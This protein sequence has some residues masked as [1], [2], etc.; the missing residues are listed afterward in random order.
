MDSILIAGGCGFIGS[1]FV[2][3]YLNAH[4]KARVAVLDK[5]TYAG[6]PENLA[7]LKGNPR[8]TFVRGDIG[9][10]A[11]VH[12]WAARVD[13]IVNFAAE[14]HVDRSLTEPDAFLRTGVHGVYT[15]LEAVRAH[16][17]VKRFLQI[18]TDE[19]YGSIE[20]GSFAE[21]DLLAPSSP[22]SAA[23][24]AGDL[25]VLAYRKTWELPILLTRASNNYGPYQ[26]PEKLIPL[27]VTNAL[28]DQPLPLYGDGLNVRDWL[29]V[30]DHCSAIDLVLQKGELGGIYN[31]GAGEERTNVEITHL[32]LEML[33]KPHTLIKPVED[34]KGH[35]RRYSISTDRIRALGWKPRANF[36]DSIRKTI[37]WYRA[38]RSWWEPIKSGA[39]KE[40]YQQQYKQLFAS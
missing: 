3:Y 27:F 23:K 22:Y 1:N 26:Y 8:F 13:A 33:G 34:R 37:E 6:N 35:D 30:E 38:H 36:E 24:A 15:L 18:S 9:D 21:T 32:I 19:V 28:N 20:K 25:L 16:T 40:Y 31:I 2:R 14:T 11:L 39:F 12:E 17:N 29:Y 10:A 5:L 4:P 7:D